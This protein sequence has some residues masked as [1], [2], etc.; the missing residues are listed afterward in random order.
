MLDL[1]QAGRV[2]HHDVDVLVRV[3]NLVH[4][5]FP[6]PLLDAVHPP[7]EVLGG[8]TTACFVAREPAS[9]AVRS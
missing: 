9:G 4:P 2:S 7:R 6:V 3:G 1:D 5:L 8:E